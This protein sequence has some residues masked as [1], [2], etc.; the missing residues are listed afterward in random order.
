MA[1]MGRAAR[2]EY[3][4]RYTAESNYAALMKIYRRV[5]NAQMP[6]PKPAGHPGPVPAYAHR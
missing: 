6:N 3:E 4:R 2:V 1:E 5:L